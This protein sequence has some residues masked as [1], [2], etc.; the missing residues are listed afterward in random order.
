MPFSHRF[1]GT[2]D[3]PIFDLSKW[4]DTEC[5]EKMEVVCEKV[6]EIVEC[7]CTKIQEDIDYLKWEN[8]ERQIEIENIQEMLKNSFL[9]SH[10]LIIIVIIT[11]IILLFLITYIFKK[12]KIEENAN[13]IKK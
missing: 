8:V 2:L 10:W 6:P 3:E 4:Y 12:Q 11:D 9:I 13:N 7:N 5:S 1:R